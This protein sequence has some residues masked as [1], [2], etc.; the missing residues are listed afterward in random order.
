LAVVVL[1]VLLRLM[2]E[3]QESLARATTVGRAAPAL[4]HR[5]QMVA[6]A[7]LVL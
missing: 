3:D 4:F 6:V 2:L 1:A 7:V 5:T